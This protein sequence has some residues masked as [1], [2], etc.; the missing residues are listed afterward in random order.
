MFLSLHIYITVLV[1]VPVA[2]LVT[3][4]TQVSAPVLH[5]CALPAPLIFYV[6]DLAAFYVIVFC[7]FPASA[8]SPFPI[9]ANVA[10]PVLFCI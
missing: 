6:P 10:V 1:L 9:P 3:S 4:F 8:P 7:P 5:S 2:C